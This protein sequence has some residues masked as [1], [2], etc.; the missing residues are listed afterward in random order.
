MVVVTSRNSLSGLIAHDGAHR[1]TLETLSHDE[2]LTLL[3]RVI[4]VA[5]ADLEPQHLADLA[6]LCA[7]LPLALRIAGERV[8]SRK[9]TA[10][11]ALV[12]E[13]SN[14]RQRLDLLATDDDMGLAPRAVFSWSYQA[15]NPDVARMFRLLGLHPTPDISIA[16]AAALAD[17][18]P[19]SAEKLLDALANVH[20]IEHSVGNRFKF[21]DLLRVYARERADQEESPRNRK[22]AVRRALSWYLH[23]SDSAD[24][25]IAPRRLHVNLGPPP[26]GCSPLN[27]SAPEQAIDWC[28]RER[29]NLVAATRQAF[30]SSHD[31]IAWQIPAVLWGF[32]HLRK[33]WKDWIATTQV[34]LAAAR[35]CRD[36][37]A[38][39][40]TL[41]NLGVAFY[42]LRRLEDAVECY[43]R[44]ETLFARVGNLRGLA[45]AL[46][47]LG[48]SYRELSQLSEAVGCFDRALE[49]R[50][51]VGDR[52]GEGIT[53][54]NLGEAYQGLHDPERAVRYIEQALELF[55][56]L[57]D[58]WG[59][60]R[61]LNNLGE[62]CRALGWLDRAIDFF[63]QALPVRYAAGDLYGSARTLEGLGNA[64]DDAGQP[65]RARDAW[66]RALVILEEL[67]DRHAEEIRILIG[68]NTSQNTSTQPDGPTG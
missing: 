41:N 9:Y 38:E 53:L 50:R 29:E 49:I 54:N 26:K 33:P 67:G 65:D 12:D 59:E 4:G 17:L 30:D 18:V 57:R 44:A 55:R 36:Q 47:N 40:V 46:S 58:S 32:F 35:R 42:D 25:V 23:S 68:K 28:E 31:Q 21:H 56:E 62:A 5:R 39:A 61:T 52:W 14:Q 51:E 60:A 43:K 6:H 7:D 11:S 34:G 24:R 48:N 22:A 37:Q 27:F 19:Q 20:L 16:V 45:S 66:S 10:M 64:L 63:E 2:S 15:L 13:L 8:A 3:R 1:I